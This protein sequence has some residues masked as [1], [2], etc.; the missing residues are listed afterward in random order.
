MRPE[1][2]QAPF[3]A[4]NHAGE[5]LGWDGTRPPAGR[6]SA[7]VNRRTP[8]RKYVIGAA[9]LAAFTAPGL[10]QSSSTTT[11]TTTGGSP[12]TFYVVRD[13]ST[14]KGTVTTTKPTSSTT[15]VVGDTVYHSR[16]EAEGAVKTTK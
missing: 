12:D 9:L 16:T 15:T 1:G 11:T 5:E 2:T 8:M 6:C 10:A 3:S 7:A 4:A 14:K 13:L